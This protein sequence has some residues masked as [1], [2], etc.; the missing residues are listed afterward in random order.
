MRR[1][2]W[3]GEATTL[4][5][6]PLLGPP[7]QRLTWSPA[8]QRFGRMTTTPPL[9]RLR[10]RWPWRSYQA[11]LLAAVERHLHDRRLHL[12]A[13]PGAGKTSLGLE[14]FRRLGKPALVLTP[15]LAIRDQWLLRL[16]DFMPEPAGTAS[17]WAPPE[18]T[19]TDLDRP[20]FL[21]VTTYQALL[22]RDRAEA[23]AED[24]PLTQPQTEPR[25]DL[26]SE[27]LA[28][29]IAG[30]GGAAVGTLILDE[31]HHLRQEWW[32]ALSRAVEALPELTLVSLTGT[33]PYDAAGREWV[34]YEQLCG[35]IDDEIGV[36][37]LVR[38]GTLCPHQDFV[39]AVHPEAGEVR[40][41]RE[42]E[43]ALESLLSGLFH[44]PALRAWVETHPWVTAAQPDPEDVLERPEPGVALLVYLRAT[45]GA[46]PLG[47][48]DLLGIRPEELPPLDRRWWQTL[49]AEYLLQPMHAPEL[50]VGRDR[51]AARLRAEGF[52]WRRE[53]RIDGSREAELTLASSPSKIDACVEVHRLERDAR[54]RALRQVF[55]TDLIR[56]EGWAAPPGGVPCSL[57]ALPLFDALVGSWPGEG[58]GALG[59][60]PESTALLTGRLC[61]LHQTRLPALLGALSGAE[62]PLATPAPHRPGWVRLEGTSGSR[63]V[64]A[65]TRLLMEGEI[66]ALVGTRSLLGEGWDAPAVTSLVLASYVGSFVS[67]NQMRGRAIRTDP[68]VPDKVASVWHLMALVPGLATGALDMAALAE[69]FR[70]FVGLSADGRKIESGIERLALP[71]VRGQDAMEGFNAEMRARYQRLENVRRG[72]REATESNRLGVLVPTLRSRRPPTLAPLHV[73]ATLR[74]LLLETGSLALS[75]LLWSLPDLMGAESWAG[76][77]RV[78]AVAAALVAVRLSP[79]LLRAG[80]LAARHLPVD[81][82]L[83]RMGHAVLE[84]LR[85]AGVVLTP[86]AEATVRHQRLPDGSVTV[87]L[88]GGSFQE[89]SAFADA[90]AELIGPVENPRYLITRTGSG[91]GRGRMDFHAVPALLGVNKERAEALLTAWRRHVGPGELIFTRREGGRRLLLEAR[92]RAFSNALAEHAERFDQW[93]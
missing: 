43:A 10:F 14:V 78:L 51:L 84:A 45:E 86:A 21:T 68:A 49:L 13:A 35:P 16:R 33:P 76:L 7:L 54:G 40:A 12:V 37:E 42:W 46:L 39:F 58:A 38:A 85:T 87:S 6:V 29:L 89:R 18:W 25:S 83:G 44:D 57:G 61:L 34:R 63:L 48:L 22:A 4:A 17:G 70:T 2:G 19:S 56:D 62:E 81:G 73:R 9:E 30:P 67:T 59:Q 20:A 77:A 60:G 26:P 93:Q 31:A 47:L 23:E 52:L 90:M 3:L 41:V 91:S 74:Y 80:L 66:T 69:R 15:T 88:S 65:Y 24:E 8:G 64:G 79:R 53:L 36:P 32:K 82:S 50:E 71:P 72:W 27:D 5:Y 1:H 11:R 55:L 75:G 28:S 92:G